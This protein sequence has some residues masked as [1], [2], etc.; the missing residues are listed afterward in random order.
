MFNGTSMASPQAAGGAA[1]LLSAAKATGKDVAPAALRRA[2]YTSAKPIKDV[3]T[4][5]QGYGM[6]N[7][8]DAWKLLN[9][10]VKTDRAY[11]SDAPV[12]TAP[13][14]TFLGRPRT[15]APASTTTAPPTAGGQKPGERKTYQVKRHPHQRPEARAC[16][17]PSRCVATTAPSS[18]RRWSRC[19]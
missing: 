14:R 8:P 9:R 19:R 12:C 18:R 7:V 15:V 5:A 4:Y 2:I 10:G 11:T 6:F 17:T 1:L 3:P 13:L 16:C